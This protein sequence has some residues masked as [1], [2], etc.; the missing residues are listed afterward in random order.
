MIAGVGIQVCSWCGVW[1]ACD[2]ILSFPR[3]LSSLITHTPVPSHPHTLDHISIMPANSNHSTER[4]QPAMARVV[5]T[6][7]GSLPAYTLMSRPLSV[8]QGI[9]LPSTFT[10]APPPPVYAAP[11]PA[12]P[13][14]G[15]GGDLL[16]QLNQM[17]SGAA[18]PVFP[19]RVPPPAQVAPPAQL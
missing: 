15:T 2:N 16:S 10:P 18:P 7:G 11:S 19:R 12:V 5:N 8:P 3:P 9:S 6:P 13:G 17:L 1:F 4:M 14:L